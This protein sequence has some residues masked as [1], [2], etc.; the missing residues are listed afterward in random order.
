MKR[1]ILLSAVVSVLLLLCG[2][3][4]GQSSATTSVYPT[5]SGTTGT[6]FTA[7]K[8]SQANGYK[9]SIGGATKIFG[10]GT[11]GSVNS[12]SLIIGNTAASGKKYVLVSDDNGNFQIYDSLTTLGVRLHIS[13]AAASLGNIGIGTTAPAATALMD[14]TSTTKGFLVPRMTSA[15]RTAIASPATGLLVYQTDGT[16]GLYQFKAVGGWTVI[17]GGTGTV[18]SVSTAAAN[19]GVTATWSQASPAP[20]LTIGLGAITPS[21]VTTT[22]NVSGSQLISTVATG[23]A[24]LVVTSTTP[25]ANLS[26][27]GNAATATTATT[28]TTAG[29]V[30]GTGVVAN[31][32]LATMPANTLKGNNTGATASAADLTVAQVKT[33]LNLTGTNSGDVTLSSTGENYLSISGQQITANPVNLSGSNVTGNL[34]VNKLNSGTGASPT[35]FWRGDGT[36]ATPVG[37]GG[38]ISSLGVSGSPQT[39]TAQTF[40]TGTSGTDFNITSATNTHTFNIPNASASARGLLT[41]A[42]WTTFNSKAPATGGTGYIQNGTGVQASSN[43]NISGNGTIGNNLTVTGTSLILGSFSQSGQVQMNFRQLFNAQ[44]NGWNVGY[45]SPTTSDFY[46]FGGETAAFRLY[47]SSTERMTVLST[48]NVGI[49]NTNP[50]AKLDIIM[51]STA[52]QALKLKSVASQTTSTFEIQDAAGAAVVQVRPTDGSTYG[53]TV[54]SIN[55]GNKTNNPAISVSNIGSGVSGIVFNQAGGGSVELSEFNLTP[56]WRYTNKHAK[57]HVENNAFDNSPESFLFSH[58][59]QPATGTLMTLLGQAGQTGDMLRVKNGASTDVFRVTAPGGGYYADAVSI[60]TTNIPSGYKL[61]VGGNVIAEKVRVK[62]QSSGWP[63]YVFEEKYPLPS[64]KET[65]QFILQNKHLPGVPSAAQIEKE[66]LD[67]GDGQA[68]LLKKI[69]ELTLHVIELDKKVEKLSK[70]N[71]DLKKKGEK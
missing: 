41:S 35:T 15:Q 44:A 23:T 27:G 63:D 53:Q 7:I 1:Y 26:I 56:I 38:G 43:F 71:E 30:T 29:S 37:G 31:S 61:A 67:L 33:M 4:F 19:N 42:D 62:L 12:P 55:Q 51:T 50:G 70:E 8:S 36:W 45:V 16:E 60:A 6:T 54:L 28:A 5:A 69:E 39:G 57:F 49:G 11:V 25:V 20:A 46:I 21:S 40:A 59:N 32:N 14:I 68:V 3:A 10:S 2:T 18:T 65:E 13:G 52:Q 17:G 58:G 48:G 64:L 47:T 24:P 66:G 9:L 34:P 22:G